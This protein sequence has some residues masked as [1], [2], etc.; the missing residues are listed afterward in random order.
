MTSAMA[1]KKLRFEGDP[2][3]PAIKFYDVYFCCKV[4]AINPRPIKRLLSNISSKLNFY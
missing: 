2:T 3:V 1:H 4:G